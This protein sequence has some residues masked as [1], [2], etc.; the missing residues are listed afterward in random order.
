[1]TAL[2]FAVAT[3]IGLAAVVGVS[4]PVLADPAGPT[5]YRSEVVSIE[6]PTDVVTVEI[7]GGDSFVQLTAT[8]GTD[9][10]VV[11]YRGEP[12]LWFRP[13]GSVAENRNSPTTYQNASRY[14][15]E[16]PADLDP[17]AEPD[18]RDVAD[19]HRWA[20][21]D[22]RAHWMQTTR[23][24]GAAPGDQILEAVIPLQVDGD[25][26]AVTVASTWVPAPSTAP[27]WVGAIA[28]LALA[29]GAALARRRGGRS[30][31]WLLAPAVLATVVGVWQYTS[32]PSETGPRPVWWALPLIA[33]ICAVAATVA[34]WRRQR[35]WADAATLLVGVELVV[36]GWIK[37]DGLRAAIIPTGA[38]GWLD[39]GSVAMALTAGLGFTVLALVA[40]FAPGRFATQRVQGGLGL[41]ASGPPVSTS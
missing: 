26:V 9:V 18:W 36:W 14:G 25:D 1:M 22:H 32:L 34:E 16:E 37:R 35:F 23:P 27:I 33:S 39:R 11:G 15:S 10:I 24:L 31:P 38:P 5:D 7:V 13:D 19:G 3:V 4:S 29:V 6:P 2:R 41:A 21:H 20:W 17:A 30:A 28:G 12:Y 40:L 8:P